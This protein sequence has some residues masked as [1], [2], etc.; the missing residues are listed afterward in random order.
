MKTWKGTPGPWKL[1]I[2]DTWSWDYWIQGANFGTVLEQERATYSTGQQTLEETMAGRRMGDA[3]EV[4]EAVEA[5]RLQLANL[6]AIAEVPAMI[7][8]LQLALY[9]MGYV[10]WAHPNTSGKM[11]RQA[12]I[13][14]TK[15]ILAKVLD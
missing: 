3:E 15:A 7:E 2:S 13:D 4:A 12:A 10:E 6:K 14:K 11:V 1:K 8:A 9:D 5:N